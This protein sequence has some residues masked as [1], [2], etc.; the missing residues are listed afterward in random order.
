MSYYRFAEIAAA[1]CFGLTF[2]AV[3]WWEIA[4]GVWRALWN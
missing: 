2:A 3:G 4:D 1:L